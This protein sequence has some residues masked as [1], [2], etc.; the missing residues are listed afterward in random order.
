MRSKMHSKWPW[1]VALSIAAILPPTAVGQ[2][3]FHKLKQAAENGVKQGTQGGQAQQGQPGLFAGRPF[4]YYCTAS[5]SPNPTSPINVV[6]YYYSPIFSVTHTSNAKND[7]ALLVKYA[8]MWESVL[9]PHG[10]EF[11]GDNTD[12][13]GT[14]SSGGYM[15]RAQTVQYQDHDIK[16][17][18]DLGYGKAIMTD[19]TP[20]KGFTKMPPLPSIEEA[21]ARAQARIEAA[22][23]WYYCVYRGYD[24]KTGARV[25]YFSTLFWWGMPAQRRGEPDHPLETM[26]KDWMYA[27][28]MHGVQSQIGSVC[29]SVSDTDNGD[30]RLKAESLEKAKAI[31]DQDMRSSSIGGGKIYTTD[32]DYNKVLALSKQQPK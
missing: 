5:Y 6:S 20:E 28:K 31:M 18:T 10:L 27:L 1:L 15:D 26:T 23:Q 16:S 24:F 2:G 7:Q 19:W 30:L 17:N 32:W 12:V 13:D 4:Y 8:A 14:C 29:R 11:P 25:T 9:R 21:Q 3:F 22:K